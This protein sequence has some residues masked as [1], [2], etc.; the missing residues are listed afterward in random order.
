[1]RWLVRMGAHR[2]TIPA[3][4]L[5]LA[6]QEL[7]ARLHRLALKRTEATWTELEECPACEHVGERD[8]FEGWEGTPRDV[9][10]GRAKFVVR[11][12]QCEH[13]HPDQAQHLPEPEL[14][15]MAREVL[16]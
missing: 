5:E 10:H 12:P 6:E 7:E 3:A 8:A 15:A 4:S 9:A 2:F 16:G 13:L 14:E 1:M 11:C